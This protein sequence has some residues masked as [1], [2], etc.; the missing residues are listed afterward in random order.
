MIYIKFSSPINPR[1]SQVLMNFL[2]EKI[3]G[4][5]KEFYF[6]ISSPGGSVN[7]GI[8]LYNFIRALPAKII[9]HNIG[10]IDS[11][12][13][14]IFLAADERY[15]NQNS[16]FLFHGVGINIPPNQRFEEKNLKE[17][18]TLIERDQKNI[19]DIIAER[20]KLTEKE[21]IEMFFRAKTKNPQ[22]AKEL[23]IIQDIKLAKIPEGNQIV[24]L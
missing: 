24:S 11:I 5:Q 2:S 20:T 1:T 8:V 14:V 23:G 17:Q 10:V 12:A 16:S 7:D 21:I 19:A 6:L 3:S 9:M 4:G 15:S 22:E 13:T 18:L